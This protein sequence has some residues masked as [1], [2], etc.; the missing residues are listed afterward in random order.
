MQDMLL[1]LPLITASC[2]GVTAAVSHRATGTTQPNWF[3]T[4]PESYQGGL[5]TQ[6]MVL[7]E[8]SVKQP[9][10]QLPPAQRLSSPKRTQHSPAMGR[11]LP[12]TLW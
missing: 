1:A 6:E 3:Q 10:V 7:I 11:I 2:V 9:Q 5:W 12:M 4:S 8:Y